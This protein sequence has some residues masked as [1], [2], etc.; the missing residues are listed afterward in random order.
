MTNINFLILKLRRFAFLLF[1][2]PTIG[3][4]GSLFFHNILVQYNYTYHYFED[5]KKYPLKKIC[6]SQNNYCIIEKLVKAQKFDDCPKFILDTY[7]LIKLYPVLLVL[8]DYLNQARSQPSFVEIF[9][10][11]IFHSLFQEKS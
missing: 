9:L 1:L 5:G 2:V 11:E 6:N 3:L 8:Q 10:L 4:L 7:F